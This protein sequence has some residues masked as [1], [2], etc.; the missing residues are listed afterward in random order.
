MAIRATITV[1]RASADTKHISLSAK[2][3]NVN[4]EAIAF[5]NPD[6]KNQ[7]FYETTTLSD[8]SFTLFEKNVAEVIALNESIGWGYEKPISETV[9]LVENF[10]KAVIYNRVFSDA[11]ALDDASQIDKDFYGNKGNVAFMLD[12][13]GLEH[14]KILTDS[15]TVG[16][17]VNVA[18]L[19]VR[20]FADI[21][22][23]SDDSFFNLYKNN[24][25][26]LGLSELT[27]KGIS[28]PTEDSVTVSDD[29]TLGVDS[30]KSE[31]ITVS[32]N[33]FFDMGKD[34]VEV[35]G[36]LE[37][38]TK[39]ISKP[40]LELINIDDDSILDIKPNKIDSFS[41]VD[42]YS[43]SLAKYIVD[44]FTLDD[45]A[46]IDK[47]FYGNKGNVLGL[48]EVV[49]QGIAK[50]LTETTTLL[51]TQETSLNKPFTESVTFTDTFVSNISK[52]VTDAFTLDDSALIDK[53]YFGNKGNIIGLTEVV[54]QGLSKVE[55]EIITIADAIGLSYDK[56]ETETVSVSDVSL[57]S[58][59]LEKPETI[60]LSETQLF[61]IA[62]SIT[63]G[64][65]LDDTAL[66]D[67]DANVNKSNVIGFSEV[68]AKVVS[69]D[70][71]VAETLTLTEVI[72]IGFD[73]SRVLADTFTFADSSDVHVNKKFYDEVRIW[74]ITPTNNSLGTNIF[75]NTQINYQSPSN[76]ENMEILFN[77][78]RPDTLAF[79]EVMARSNTK[80]LT[81]NLTFIDD[82]GVQLEKTLSDGLGLDDSALIDKD[83]FGNK[84]NIVGLSDL[85][86]IKVT[87]SNVLGRKPLNIMSFN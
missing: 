49:A 18:M 80:T 75:N 58:Y 56:P 48:T 84:G 55:S 70:R 35:I 57:L 62:K 87:Q 66:I 69:F 54:T 21:T 52:T 29:S 81:E 5:V 63:D 22:S 46:L 60:T 23:L 41:F 10:V 85:V 71:D 19:W 38:Q 13:I 4:A 25:E 47:D 74:D 32:D 9:A 1:V 72:T 43:K 50:N 78:G 65:T 15:Y 20:D 8:I 27:L 76:T 28:K 26:V 37:T 31:A 51:D 39:G 77:S 53:D 64:F 42:I 3:T 2:T 73:I 79:S 82:F 6:S 24:T 61:D 17:V 86:G 12:I 59:N 83:Y 30:N 67:K 33:S 14:D 7:W 45:S 34:N 16:D 36:L 11:F 44:A 68:F 40:K